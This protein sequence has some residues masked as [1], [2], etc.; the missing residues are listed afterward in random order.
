M[1]AGVAGTNL[2]WLCTGREIFPA[3]LAAIDEARESV[4][5]E[6]YTYAP[7]RLGQQFRD[8]LVNARKRGVR[9]SVLFDALG[10]L[11]MPNAFFDELR[12]LGGEARRF[13]ALWLSRF[14]IRDH[15]KL[16]V[17]DRKVAFVGGFNIA[18]EYEGDGVTRGWRDLG[19]KVEGPLAE[20]L[21]E[22]FQEM[23]ERANLPQRQLQRLTR[24]GAKRTVLARNEQLL[25][26]GPARGRSP[27]KAALR[28]D[29]ARART[30]QIIVAYFLPSWRIRRALGRVARSGGSLDII[31]PGISDVTLSQLAAQSLYRRFLKVGARI[32]EYQP[33]ILHA[34]L[35]IIDDTVYVGSANLD[36]RSLNINYEL[37]IRFHGK[38][39]ADRARQIFANTR[40]HCREVTAEEWR[41][42]RSLWQ[43]FKQRWA[44][45][46][47]ARVDPRI[48]RW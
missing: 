23:F 4:C 17:C 40:A 31:L 16:L 48:S 24:S 26:S 44:Y 34:K 27:I 19:L 3:M 30:V 42:S 14:G 28:R 22:S 13:N 5:L 35:L 43:R 8:A 20:A 41:S 36:Q 21:S 37:M 47:L 46:F 6:T 12:A 45:F 9:V 1:L 39:M 10:S 15:R 25:L 33:Q 18:A 11:A 29:L 7:D 32:F 38:S 2:N